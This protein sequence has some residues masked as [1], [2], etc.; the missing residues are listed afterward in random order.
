M[1]TKEFLRLLAERTGLSQEE[2]RWIFRAMLAVAKE[3]MD[4]G[5]EW[6]LPGIG[7]LGMAWAWGRFRPRFRAYRS[8]LQHLDK[9]FVENRE[10]PI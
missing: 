8:Y 2:V 6:R 5:D 4:E 9:S 1:P 10:V 3:A 7:R